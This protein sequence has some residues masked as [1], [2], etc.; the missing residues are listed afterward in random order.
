MEDFVLE[1]DFHDF[2][3][4]D[5]DKY[6]FLKI[7]SEIDELDVDFLSFVSCLDLTEYE[8][9]KSD[10][11]EKEKSDILK[12]EKEKQILL[13]KDK[14]KEIKQKRFLDISKAIKTNSLDLLFPKATKAEIRKVKFFEKRK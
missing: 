7:K 6:I 10:K 8:K 11:L 1:L 3:N 14:Q 13:K 12:K 2:L 4:I 5:N 9:E